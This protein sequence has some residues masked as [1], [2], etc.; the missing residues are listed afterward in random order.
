MHSRSI[1]LKEKIEIKICYRDA[2]RCKCE[3]ILKVLYI[4]IMYMNNVSDVICSS[5]TINSNIH[6]NFRLASKVLI[7]FTYWHCSPFW[8]VFQPTG[9]TGGM[10]DSRSGRWQSDNPL[11]KCLSH[12]AVHSAPK[13]ESPNPIIASGWQTTCPFLIEYYSS[14]SGIS[15]QK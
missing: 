15:L 14:V 12:S 1:S 5:I 8:K 2:A 11:R 3:H 10:N 13:C 9:M 4:C 6:Q 7:L